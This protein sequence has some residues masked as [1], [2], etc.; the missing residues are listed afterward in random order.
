V[1]RKFFSGGRVG[2]KWRGPS[3]TVRIRGKGSG[4]RVQGLKRGSCVWG[5]GVW[6]LKGGIYNRKERKGRRERK[7]LEDAVR[8]SG[9]PGRLNH[10][11]TRINTNERNC[12]EIEFE[13]SDLTGGDLLQQKLTGGPDCRV[14]RGSSFAGALRRT[15]SF[16]AMTR[17]RV[18]GVETRLPR[19]SGTAGRAR[20]SASFEVN[21]VPPSS[22]A[23]RPS[24]KRNSCLDYKT[25]VQCGC[26]RRWRRAITT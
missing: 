17:G 1:V 11:C 21:R 6:G 23:I 26:G 13:I 20:I 12:G 24:P 8:R 7:E 2:A 5:L 19:R 15:R 16:L 4:F 14:T 10:E 9:M 18:G 3:R 25:G 22:L